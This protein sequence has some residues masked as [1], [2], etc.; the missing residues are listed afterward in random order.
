MGE[1]TVKEKQQDKRTIRRK[2]R[3]R[4]QIISYVALAV[5]L[6][7][8]VIGIVI[9]VNY[10]SK[11]VENSRSSEEEVKSQVDQILSN[12]PE[13]SQP[14]PSDYVPELTP[15]EKL[16]EI[17]N[18]AIDV[19]PLEDKVAGLF[20][21]TPEAITGVNT[22]VKAGESTK[23]ALSKNA[24]GGLI[25]FQKNMKSA[26]Q[27]KEM[28]NNSVL[29]SRY[30][31]FVGVD[32]EGGTV[33]RVASSGLAKDVGTAATIGATGDPANAYAA[34]QAIGTYLTEFGFNLNF[35][36][37]ADLNNVDNSIIGDRSYGSDPAVVAQMVASVI[38]GLEEKGVSACMKH[39]PGIGS[40]TQD[41][42]NGL[43]STDRAAED[44]R[45]GEFVVFQSGIESGVDFIMI[46]HMAAP[47]LSGNQDPC[48]FSE[49]VVTNIL[50]KELG[51]DGVVITDA[52]NM[53]AI[54][55]YNSSEEA[56]IKALKAGCD[57]LLMPE[58]YQEAY[59][60]VLQAVKDGT[61][62]EQRINDSLL[63]IYR[64]KYAGML[65]E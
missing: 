48:T 14:D 60:G 36:P 45:V 23:E 28:I 25:Y 55:E 61:I 50:R 3:I 32:E 1:N 53:K 39:F 13:I 65:K 22:A 47:N 24:V 42:H 26:D 51:Y 54:S 35:A 18:A 33:A 21:V 6:L 10:I 46:T 8:V 2:R 4:N 63:R 31:L 30:P 43:A 34:G 16:D 17:I 38:K 11:H 12:E 49:E 52:L 19:M 62:S 57:M 64:I 58:D 5:V 29:Y 59:E 9:A 56:A 20:V 37:V 27:L 7:L 15:E 41:T 44:F 40:S